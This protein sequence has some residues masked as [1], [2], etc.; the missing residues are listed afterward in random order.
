MGDLLA[1]V[2]I[3]LAPAQTASLRAW[4]GRKWL[5]GLRVALQIESVESIRQRTERKTEW[6]SVSEPD[7]VCERNHVQME[8][9]ASRKR[10]LS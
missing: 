7:K 10:E 1:G 8:G 4:Q 3:S 5:Y 9:H 2:A 6:E